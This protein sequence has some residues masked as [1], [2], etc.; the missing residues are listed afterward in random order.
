[1]TVT[2]IQLT[3]VPED[4]TVTLVTT[5]I[6]GVT[7]HGR[8]ADLAALTAEDLVATVDLSEVEL[9]QGSSSVVADIAAP[10]KGLVWCSGTYRVQISV[11]QN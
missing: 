9:G 10:D 2:N 1:M 7:V 11:Q 6:R 8:T 3:G 4:Y 5:S